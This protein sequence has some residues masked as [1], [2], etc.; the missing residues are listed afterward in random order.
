MIRLLR[1]N[2]LGIRQYIQEG[3]LDDEK[4]L[5]GIY[6]FAFG[7]EFLVLVIEYMDGRGKEQAYCH[8]MSKVM[9]NLMLQGIPCN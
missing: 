3:G 1:R 6:D 9:I 4:M 8:R 7:E 5:E 2:E